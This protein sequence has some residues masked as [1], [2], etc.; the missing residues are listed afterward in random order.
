MFY[1]RG[2]CGKYSH[3]AARSATY[4]CECSYLVTEYFRRREINV[5]KGKGKEERQ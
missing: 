1:V 4:V 2:T 5:R 3:V